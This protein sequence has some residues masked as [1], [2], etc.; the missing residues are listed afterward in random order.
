MVSPACTAVR[1]TPCP[2][3]LPSEDDED[4]EE[5]D[6]EGPLGGAH[7]G[8]DEDDMGVQLEPFNLKR[9][10]EL[11]DFDEDGNYVERRVE[12]DIVDAWLDGVEVDATSRI[13]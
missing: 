9:E 12:K 1:L 3:C 2:A 5:E 13:A 7:G 6:D 4:G 10:R 11:G 8:A